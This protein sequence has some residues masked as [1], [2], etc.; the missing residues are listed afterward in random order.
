MHGMVGSRDIIELKTLFYITYTRHR[1]WKTLLLDNAELMSNM[2]WTMYTKLRPC[3]MWWSIS[4][5]LFIEI[6]AKHIGTLLF[7][8]IVGSRAGI[9]YI[10]VAWAIEGMS[11]IYSY[12]IFNIL[13]SSSL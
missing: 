6:V 8:Y 5:G 7:L 4:V 2:R 12:Y 11:N 3:G 1:Q 9:G 10:G 13:P